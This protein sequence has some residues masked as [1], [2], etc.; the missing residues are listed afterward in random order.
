MHKGSNLAGS[1][2]FR[3]I[4]LDVSLLSM[5]FCLESSLPCS[6]ILAT[7]RI[8]VVRK[9]GSALL[10]TLALFSGLSRSNHILVQQQAKFLSS[11]WGRGLFSFFVGSLQFSNWNM[12]DLT[13]G[14]F[15][16]ILGCLAMGV[17]MATARGLKTL[18][19]RIKDE[20][21][22]KRKWKEHDVNRDGSLDVKELTAFLQ[23]AR[24]NMSR[25]EVAAVFLALDKNFDDRISYQELLEWW[26]SAGTHEPDRILI[27]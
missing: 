13:V 27:V 17:S 23:D 25:N 7:A 20:S 5:V 16:M 22:L 2:S 6:S 15:M 10:I 3:L 12:L 24:V 26:K 1:G 9:V 19:V 18:K 14:G 4:F 21:T 8:S 11:T